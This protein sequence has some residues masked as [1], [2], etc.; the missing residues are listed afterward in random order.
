[1]TSTLGLSINDSRTATDRITS[2]NRIDNRVDNRITTDNRVDNSIVKIKSITLA[3][4][5]TSCEGDERIRQQKVLEWISPIT[6]HDQQLDIFSKRTE[7]TGGWFLKGE[8]IKGWIEGGTKMVFCEG[9]RS[10]TIINDLER[11]FA[12]ETSV[13]I[14]YIY[15]NYKLRDQYTASALVR[16]LCRQLISSA[17]R[18]LGELDPRIVSIFDQCKSY[19]TF[20]LME[21]IEAVIAA[22]SCF[23]NAFVV[24]DALDE[25]ADEQRD[26]FL[27][28]LHKLVSTVID[29]IKTKPEKYLKLAK[30]VLMWIAYAK[31]P[32]TITELQHALAVPVNTTSE[33]MDLEECALILQERIISSC[34]GLVV[35]DNESQV[36][37][38]VHYTTQDYVHAQTTTFIDPAP[39]IRISAACVNYLCFPKIFDLFWANSER[40]S[41]TIYAARHWAD[42]AREQS[43]THHSKMIVE[44]LSQEETVFE[45]MNLK[46]LYEA[47][48]Q[49]FPSRYPIRTTCY[50]L[51]AA[52]WF[53]LYNATK[54]LIDAGASTNQHRLHHP[55]ES[56][57]GAGDVALTQLLLENGAD[58]HQSKRNVFRMAAEGGS[59]DLV[60]LLLANGANVDSDDGEKALCGAAKGGHHRVVCLLLENGAQANKASSRHYRST[61]A[62]YPYSPLHLAASSGSVETVQ[63]LLVNGAEV[64]LG[65]KGKFKDYIDFSHFLGSECEPE[66]LASVLSDWKRE[67]HDHDCT[68]LHIAAGAGHAAVAE[69]LLENGADANLTLNSTRQGELTAMDVAAMRG[70]AQIV[71]LLL[72]RG[73]PGPWAFL[74]AANY[75]HVDIVRMLLDSGTVACTIAARALPLAARQEGVVRM[76]LDR[77]LGTGTGLRVAL[78]QAVTGNCLGVVRMLLAA[79]VDADAGSYLAGPAL[80]QAARHADLDLV[81]LLLQAGARAAPGDPKPLVCLT[82]LISAVRSG[83]VAFVKIL[84]EHG[85]DPNLTAGREEM[86]SPLGFAAADNRNVIV[87]ILLKAGARIYPATL[88]N[89][90]ARN[91]EDMVLYLTKIMESNAK[92]DHDTTAIATEDGEPG[93]PASNHESEDTSES[94]D[95]APP[96]E[97]PAKKRRRKH[98]EDVSERNEKE[99]KEERNRKEASVCREIFLRMPWLVFALSVFVVSVFS[100]VAFLDF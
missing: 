54:L 39:H 63:M 59:V 35:M 49:Y 68:P 10:S 94:S 2:D 22:I 99:E 8:T 1:M 85:A 13:A 67:W 84:L 43:N 62:G 95:E 47:K 38:L 44:F 87:D 64:N 51:E 26:S 77:G 60:R 42:H 12:S 52:V 48:Y 28:Y 32:L 30:R 29:R 40:Y 79:G 41:L 31:G 34:A 23:S 78:Q 46:S 81:E 90:R 61:R 89:A 57:I 37:R 33:E 93:E 86:D 3:S 7:N 17:S 55:L 11:T 88:E 97:R 9:I 36:V 24:V 65:T 66:A 5:A 74:F 80:A 21:V 58:M 45:A 75:G 56:A 19:T 69:L 53:R 14:A 92:S 27:V 73:A 50:P 91:K 70:R 83:N 25:I 4:T 96:P 98:E 71:R 76:L 100:S 6:F 20:P 18:L 82:P 15:C 16:S 72:D